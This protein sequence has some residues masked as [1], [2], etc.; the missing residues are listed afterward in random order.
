MGG[1][2]CGVEPVMKT[3]GVMKLKKTK[4]GDYEKKVTFPVFSGYAVRIVFT[5]D[6]PKS[7]ISRY[8]NAG[9]AGEGDTNAMVS[10]NSEGCH[11][12][13]K[14]MARTGVIAHEAYHAVRRMLDWIGARECDEEVVA[15][16]LT[17]L[18]DVIA[19][20]QQRVL[21]VKSS[22]TGGPNGNSHS[23]RANGSV[24]RLQSRFDK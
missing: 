13:F 10:T 1:H 17:H 23:Q 22:K 12:F 6:L 4:H 15:Y 3:R 5:D 7:R 19:V 11:I 24:P 16:H 8:G 21:A 9:A 2:L 14:P 20:F 18:V